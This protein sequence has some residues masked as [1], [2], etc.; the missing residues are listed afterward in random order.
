MRQ[1]P[2]TIL[3]PDCIFEQLVEPV[4]ALVPECTALPVSRDGE[5]Q[6]EI[7]EG[8]VLL[9][10]W[11]GFSIEGFR[12]VVRETP[13]LRWIHTISAGVNHV[14]FPFLVESDIVLTNASGVSKV[15]IGEMVLAYMLQ[16]VKRMPEFLQHQKAHNWAKLPLR[17]LRGLTVGVLGLGSIGAEV[18]RLAR[19]FG[20]RVIATRNHPERGGE[21]VE[22]V[23]PPSRL[24]ELLARSDFVVITLP[25]T[26]ATHHLINND[27]LG[28]MKQEAWLINVARGSIVEQA[29]LVRALQEG[30]IGGACLDVFDQEPLPNDSPLW[31]LPNVIVTPHISQSTPLEKQRS[32][33]LYLENLR[34]YVAGE[35]LLNVVEKRELTLH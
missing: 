29:A 32:A 35:A 7:V 28:Q 15:P 9:L 2:K 26:R 4:G 22:L 8:D 20:M 5:V 1:L 16:V 10:R 31:E 11:W 33:E 34:R 24:H 17:E 14:L 12:R 3:M 21:A 19:A 6:G 25:L 13:R 18:A 23:L 27:T 30:L